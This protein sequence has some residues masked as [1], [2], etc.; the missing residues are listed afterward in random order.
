[1]RG[2][3]RIAKKFKAMKEK[4][5]VNTWELTETER[6]GLYRDILQGNT[7]DDNDAAVVSLQTDFFDQSPPHLARRNSLHSTEDTQ[8]LE[9]A[10][11]A[12]TA[13]HSVAAS[14][15]LQR[16]SS[17]DS[18]VHVRSIELRDMKVAML[19]LSQ[20]LEDIKK[21][22]QIGSQGTGSLSRSLTQNTLSA[23]NQDLS[24][25]AK[26]NHIDIGAMTGKD[27]G[28]F[29]KRSKQ[30][31]NRQGDGGRGKAQGG[32][33]TSIQRMMLGTPPS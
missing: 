27:V 29:I 4:H 12:I 8:R 28:S 7:G 23:T 19:E 20:G 2:V 26:V 30:S 14:S 24:R 32:I 25:A 11:E 22:M 10:T 21:A 18:H 15:D 13:A 3:V 6:V 31:S 16:G 9:A 5:A 33:R 1:M 17:P